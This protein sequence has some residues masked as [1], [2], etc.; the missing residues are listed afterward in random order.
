[1]SWLA[2]PVG[3]LMPPG[4]EWVGLATLVFVLGVIALTIGHKDNE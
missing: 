3:E 4:V 2:R 1:M